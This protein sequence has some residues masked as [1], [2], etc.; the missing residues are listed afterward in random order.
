MSNSRNIYCDESC[1]LLNDGHVEPGVPD[2]LMVFP[3]LVG[4]SSGLPVPVL[5]VQC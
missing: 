2:Q 1:Y 4:E 3:F 5:E